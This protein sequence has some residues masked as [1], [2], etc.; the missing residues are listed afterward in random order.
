MNVL[1]DLAVLLPAIAWCVG[2]PV[3]YFVGRRPRAPRV[4]VR[5][6]Y[7]RREEVARELAPDVAVVLARR[8]MAAGAYPYRSDAP[9]RD[10]EEATSAV[11]EALE[12]RGI[13][14]VDDA[15]ARRIARRRA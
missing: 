9:I 1:T 4:H 10:A 15:T 5:V 12:D 11:L 7:R 14:F 13:A 8:A 6:D 2:M 3:G